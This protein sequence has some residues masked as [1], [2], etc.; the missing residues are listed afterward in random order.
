MG[1]GQGVY[2]VSFDSPRGIW[3]ACR[4]AWCGKCFIPFPQDRFPIRSVTEEDGTPAIQRLRDQD[5]FQKA[6]NGDHL[7]CPF[8][9]G[10]CHFRNIQKRDPVLDIRQ[11]AYALVTI[12]RASLDSPWARESGTVSG[13]LTILKQSAALAE[14]SYDIDLMR[15]APFP[16]Q[17]PHPVEDTFGMLPAIIMLE[18]SLK[19]GEKTKHIQ[20]GTIRKVRSAFSNLYHT[21]CQALRLLAVR[22]DKGTRQN[23]SDS[24]TYSEWFERFN[25][26]CHKRMGDNI[27]PDRAATIE[28]ILAMQAHYER[29]FRCSHTSRDLLKVAL[30]CCFFVLGFCAGLRGEELPLMSLDAIRKYYDKP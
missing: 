22:R 13:N 18:E 27:R 7:L 16:A 15:T 3:T 6:R 21:T 2:C 9:C 30:H 25:L 14:S 29:L 8:Q 17:G 20:W 19:P 24:P 1:R 4:G 12:R 28:V 26:G 23:F 11:D 10:L 5:R